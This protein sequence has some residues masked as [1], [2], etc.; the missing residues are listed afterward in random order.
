[1]TRTGRWTTFSLYGAIL[2]AASVLLI[3]ELWA[4]QG[5]GN[6]ESGK[7]IYLE[8]CQSCHGPTGKGDSDMA[9]YLTPPPANLA[10]KKT[11]AKTDAELRKMILEGRP[12]TAMSS[13]EGTFEEAQLADLLAYIRSLKP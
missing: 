7:K 9:A 3:G 5:K 2:I 11:Q 1:M 6:P 12:G 10:A 4:A 13:Y 8:S